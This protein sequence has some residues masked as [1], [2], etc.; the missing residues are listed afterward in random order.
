MPL[1]E[2]VG[3]GAMDIVLGILRYAFVGTILVGGVLVLRAIVR[4]AR[5][6]SRQDACE[7]QS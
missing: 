6:K 7:E 4:L 3:R 1:M 5:E 2:C